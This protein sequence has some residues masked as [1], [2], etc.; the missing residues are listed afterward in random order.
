MKLNLHVTAFVSLILV[1]II[2]CFEEVKR[3][4]CWFKR[5]GEAEDCQLRPVSYSFVA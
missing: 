3:L 1:M 4:F 5:R 2:L